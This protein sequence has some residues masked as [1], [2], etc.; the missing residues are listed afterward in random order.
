MFIQISD[1]KLSWP[2]EFAAAADPIRAALGDIAI[3]IHHI[4]STSVPGLAAKDIIDVQVTVHHLG[5]A[6]VEPM[7]AAGFSHRSDLVADHQPP[8]ADH[9]ADELR[10]EVFVQP[11]GERRTNIHVRVAGAFNQRY[12]V[13]F[14]DYLRSHHD[15]RDAYG[16][17][18]RTLAR[19]FPDDLDSYYDIKDPAIDM[20]MAGAYVWAETTGWR[21]PETDA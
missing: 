13:L 12:A 7:T 2:E 19:L 4:G 10:K 6:V 8:G 1:Y 14:R 3:A 5:P 21:V 18:K 15:A 17:L 9:A 11:E 16:E 20:L